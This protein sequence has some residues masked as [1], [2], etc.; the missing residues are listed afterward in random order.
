MKKRSIHGK[1]VSILHKPPDRH[2]RDGLKYKAKRVLED[3]IKCQG[4]SFA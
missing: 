1:Y 2:R 3:A 4:L